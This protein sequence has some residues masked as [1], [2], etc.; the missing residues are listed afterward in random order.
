MYHINNHNNVVQK[1]KQMRGIHQNKIGLEKK[2]IN[3]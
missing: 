3:K 2:Y 1:L